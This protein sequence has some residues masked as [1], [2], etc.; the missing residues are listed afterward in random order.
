MYAEL[1][2]RCLAGALNQAGKPFRR[3]RRPTFGEEHLFPALGLAFQ[4]P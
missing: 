1:E 4:L 2:A 3:E